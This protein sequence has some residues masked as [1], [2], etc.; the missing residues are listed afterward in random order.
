MLKRELWR[1]NDKYG[2]NWFAKVAVRSMTTFYNHGEQL[3]ICR[4]F[5]WVSVSSPDSQDQESEATVDTEPFQF[6]KS[7]P[8]CKHQLK[9]LA[10]MCI[11]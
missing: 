5:G 9:L 1:K 4:T 7:L 3:E 6:V 10:F 2:L 11:Q 8:G